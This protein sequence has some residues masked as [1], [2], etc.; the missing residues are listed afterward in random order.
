M[1]EI[2]ERIEKDIGKFHENVKLLDESEL[3]PKEV[4]IIRLA[5]NYCDDAQAWIEKEDFYTAFASISYAHGLLDT[6][7]KLNSKE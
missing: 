3:G 5:K 6:L 7:L 1:Q 2:G 4:E